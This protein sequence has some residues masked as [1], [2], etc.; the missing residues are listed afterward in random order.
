VFPRL[1]FFRA[2][3]CVIC[4]ALIDGFVL[5]ASAAD[6]EDTTNSPANHWL[7]R[8]WQTDDGLPDNNVTGVAQT[9]DGHL[10]VATLGGLLRFDGEGFEEF[11]TTRL[12]KVPN[13]VVRSMY[14]D[15]RGRLW[16]A[17]DRGVMIRVDE[18]TARVFDT[19]DGFPDSRVAVMA[20]DKEGGVWF[21]CANDVC[22]IRD[23]KVQHFGPQEGLPT[24]GN[25]WL[26]PDASGQLW[27]ACGAKVGVFRDGH[28]QTLLTMDT[29]PVHLAAALD[30]GMW[31][32]TG[33]QVLKY[34]EGNDLQE[35]ATLPARTKVQTM[36]E[37]HTGALWIG[38][39]ADGL[40]RCEG[41]HL[42]AMPVSHPAIAALLEDREGNI[43]VGT[44]G[45]GLNLLR[46][47]AMGLVGNKG[48]LPFDVL[49]V[50]QDAEGWVWAALDNGSLA[51][52][53]GDDWDILSSAD[54]WPGGNATC[55][56]PD[57]TG[58]VWIGTRG[59]GLLH[60]QAGKFQAW[61]TH[62]GL[63]SPD[64][65]SLLQ[66]TNGDL[67]IATDLPSR[68]WLFQDGKFQEIPTPIRVRAI[69]ALAEGLN[70]I[71]WAGTSDGQILRI[72][73]RTMVVEPTTQKASPYSIRCLNTTA[74]GSLWIGYAGWGI[75][76]WHDGHY[77]RITMAQG[78]YDDYVSQMLSDGQGGVWLTSNH[79]LSQVRLADLV[80][81]AE[82][83]ST[84]LRANAYG[85]DEGLPS[86]QP[87][88]EN[89]PTA[90]RGAGN[91]LWF[92]TRKGVLTVQ[93]DKIRD[94]PIPPTVFVHV[95]KLD[96]QPVALYDSQFPLHL[97]AE[98]K[99]KD[100]RVP[101]SPLQ[102]PPGHGKIEFAFTALS[103][104][105]P[106]NVQ[107]RYRLKNFDTE[108]IEAGTQRIARYPRL[109]AG[110][111]EFDV[112]ACNE[113]GLWNETGF[114]LPFTVEPFIWQT[115]WFRMLMVMS[116]TAAIIAVVR[117]VS[118]RRLRQ[119]MAL[120]E[121]QAVLDKE[122]A[123]IAK[124]LHDDLG[125]TMTQIT[126]VLELALQQR[127][128]PDA[129]IGTVKDGLMAARE[130]IKSLDA[131]VW[132]VNPANNTLPELVAYIGQFGMEFLQQANIRCL[133]DL[134]DHPPER[135]VSAELR[136]NLFLIVKEALNNVV[137][138]AQATEVRLQISITA[139]ALDLL[140][141]DNGRGIERKPDENPG[142]GLRNMRQ[143]AEELKAEFRVESPPG[144]GTR[145]SVHYPWPPVN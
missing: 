9:T 54:G 55:V 106:E 101:G 97:P 40:L 38:T 107:F 143:R 51:R 23:D 94:N 140:I 35:I 59:R 33:T 131:A 121:Q 72:Q 69:R 78:L 30:G 84:H 81:V 116:F 25:I 117:Y 62:E 61:G 56:A 18:K 113:A 100:L 64:L 108:W 90:W 48:G 47:R 6:G 88:F 129:V 14:L 125:A 3:I 138:H 93:P 7:S 42:E 109:P 71:V 104:N 122:R 58:G 57:L 12:L 145:I 17:M 44:S 144:A 114:Q 11:S 92:S 142:D 102:L 120:L 119:R 43:W 34:N 124:D 80:D 52:G 68:L 115:W 127:P 36:L 50:C 111:Y 65:R 31:I 98:M 70:G 16:L 87:V 105:S 91:Q 82:G 133:L 28:W 73:G 22:R 103:F 49:S 46:S 1:K 4:A 5:P 15:R 137:R 45:G 76:R 79:G 126:L 112:T 75:G 86:L 95:V 20:E 83:R 24:G 37:D 26:A 60:W 41:N 77:A 67:W 10:W 53:R 123:R 66:A 141:A 13:H 27:F 89:N 99:L 29:N 130:A 139:A 39:S 136:H 21:V 132:A 74:D 85:R 118:F 19:A 32:C 110:H 135:P 63:G 8:S 128:E 96:D 134:P 2:I